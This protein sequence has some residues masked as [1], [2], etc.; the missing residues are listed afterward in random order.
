VA[1]SNVGSAGSITVSA[2]TGAANLPLTLRVCQ[3]DPATGVCV[4]PPTLTVTLNIAAGA[5]GTF[6]VFATGSGNIPFDPAANRIFVRF[7]EG[8]LTRGLTSAAVSTR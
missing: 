4:S 6:G 3:T 1:T 7:R 2:D 8:A 5:T